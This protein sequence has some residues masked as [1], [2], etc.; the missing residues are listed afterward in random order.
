VEVSVLV[1]FAGLDPYR[2]E[3][4]G[5]IT[6][7]YDWEVVVGTCEGPW[8]KAVAV[9]NAANRA[10]GDLFVVADADCFSPGTPEAVQAV[11]EGAAWA[12]PHKKVHRLT[13]DVSRTVI[14]GTE[15]HR[16]SPTDQPPYTGTFGGGI[17][18]L[19]R[20]TWN[21]TPLDPR[22]VGWGQ[23]DDSWAIALN[24]LASPCVRLQHP[25]WHLWHP[26]QERMSRRIG[27]PESK[28]LFAAYHAA[29]ND[30]RALAQIVREG[31]HAM[32]ASHLMTQTA[33][34]HHVTET[35][36]DE[37]NDATTSETTTES[38][39]LL[40]Q[41]ARIEQTAGGLVTTESLVLFLPADA[42]VDALSKVTVDGQTYELD[43]PPSKPFNP[44]AGAVGHIE[45]TVRRVA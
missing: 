20:D 24:G 40:Q 21:R 25:L 32:P 19:T 44:L 4:L 34:L 26:P 8:R 37:Y 5:Y 7:H 18:V 43:G 36:V 31:R 12:M 15:P 27:S 6:A 35:G 28:A 17:V 14:D 3:A 11:A 23:E 1:P 41:T 2:L 38:A 10:T 16:H 30:P 33:T 13:R 29:R 45:A 42:E 39:C 9:Q 22:F